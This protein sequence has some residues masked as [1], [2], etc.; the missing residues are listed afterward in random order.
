MI[1]ISEPNFSMLNNNDNNL[2]ME[3]NIFWFCNSY[4]YYNGRYQYMFQ[5]FF[6]AFCILFKFYT[7]REISL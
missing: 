3:I 2:K 4:R 1:P 5:L 6:H 7:H